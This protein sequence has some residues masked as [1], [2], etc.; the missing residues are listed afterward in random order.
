MI[1][2]LFRNPT[3][4]THRVPT[5][6]TKGQTTRVPGIPILSL[7]CVTGMIPWI[8]TLLAIVSY[9]THLNFEDRSMYFHNVLIGTLSPNAAEWLVESYLYMLNVLI[10]TQ[11]V[12]R[13]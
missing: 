5:V 4:N 1:R 3:Q 6:I 12:S 8:L 2:L 10:C 9:L 11:K 7:S 13:N